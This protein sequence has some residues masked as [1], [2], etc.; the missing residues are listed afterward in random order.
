MHPRPRK[1]STPLSPK[2]SSFGKQRFIVLNEEADFEKLTAAFVDAAHMYHS[3]YRALNEYPRRP[4][5]PVRIWFRRGQ[6]TL[7]GHH[8]VSFSLN[9][10]TKIWGGFK[11]HD[12]AFRYALYRIALDILDWQIPWRG[13]DPKLP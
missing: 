8:V 7:E 13:P 11:K 2:R 10:E 6:G 1:A 5:P 12:D 3:S 4:V 9:G